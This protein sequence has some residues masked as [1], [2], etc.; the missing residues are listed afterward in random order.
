MTKMKGKMKRKKEIE[1]C[2]QICYLSNLVLLKF[3]PQVDL[4]LFTIFY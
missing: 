3:G 4:Y 1:D 2:P